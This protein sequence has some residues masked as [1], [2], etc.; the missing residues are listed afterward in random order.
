MR[1]A[2]KLDRNHRDIVE[3]LELLGATVQSLAP[4][5]SGVPDLLVGHRNLNLLLEVKDGSL[6]PSRRRLTDDEAE[7]QFLW[8]GQ[9]AV[10]YSPEEAQMVVINYV[11]GLLGNGRQPKA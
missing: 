1:R 6:P 2:C 5:G 9:K 7:W 8:R 3:A 4:M 11:R 10:V